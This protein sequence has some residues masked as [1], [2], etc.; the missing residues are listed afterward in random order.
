MLIEKRKQLRRE[1]DRQLWSELQQF[2]KANAQVESK[3]IRS[4]RRR[5]IRR[6]CTVG[7]ALCFQQQFGDTDTWNPQE[8]P[9]K[10]K[11]LDLSD[12]GASLFTGQQME[13]G[14]HVS[15]RISIDRKAPIATQGQVLWS[16]AIPDKNAY[17]SGVQFEGLGASD[18]KRLLKFLSKMEKSLGL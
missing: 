7:I 11:L 8:H 5:A 4:Q 6:N 2:R 14:Q 10:R 17:A 13:I 12:N 1:S 9:I 15:L 18:Q 16:K 3:E